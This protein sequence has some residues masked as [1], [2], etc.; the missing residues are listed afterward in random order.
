MA[1]VAAT[2]V[3]AGLAALGLPWVV[4]ALAGVVVYA[5]TLQRFGFHRSIQEAFA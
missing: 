3:L 5:G 4:L 2:A 1:A